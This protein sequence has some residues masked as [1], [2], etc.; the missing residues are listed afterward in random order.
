MDLFHK[1]RSS[2]TDIKI[3][4]EEGRVTTSPEQARFFDVNYSIE[5]NDLGRVNIKLD[6]D[7]LT[8]IYNESMLDDQDALK[9]D[10]FEFLRDM[11]QFAKRNMLRFD[12][13]D[14]TKS[15]LDQRDYQYLAQKT[16]ENAMSE[17]KLFGT[18]KT[19]YQDIGTAKIIVKHS[20][21]VNY[22]NPAGRS[23]RIDSIYVESE[24]G[25]RFRYPHKHLNGAR[26][27][28]MHI[29]NGGNAYDEIGGYISGLSEELSKLKQF[30]SYASRSGVVSETLNDLNQRV[31][32]RMEAIRSEIYSLQKDHSYKE[33]ATQFTPQPSIEVPD[34]IRSNWVDALTIKTFNEELTDVFPYL[35]KLVNEQ[36]KELSYD[37]IVAEEQETCD[38][39]GKKPCECDDKVKEDSMFAE[40]EDQMDDITTFDYDVEEGKDGKALKK[41]E[42]Y[43]VY[44]S[45]VLTDQE[46]YDL[47]HKFHELAYKLDDIGIGGVMKEIKRRADETGSKWWKGVSKE[48]Q[49]KFGK[50]AENFDADVE[51]GRMSEIDIDLQTLANRGDEEDLIAAL[52]GE[53]GPDVADVLQNMMDDLKDELASKGMNDVMNDQDK[54]IEILWDKIVNEYSGDEYNDDDMDSSDADADALKSAG[55][56]SDEDYE[57][58]QPEKG[59]EKNKKDDLPFEPD[60]SPPSAKDQ[61]GNT[62][63]HRARHLAR[64]GMRSVM[65]KEVVEFISSLY[66]RETGTFPKG[67]EGVKIAVKKKFGETAG[68][69]A[70]FVVEKLSAKNQ[71]QGDTVMQDSSELNRIRELSGMKEEEFSYT[72]TADNV[73]AR[74]KEKG[75]RY[76]RENEKEIIGMIP[77]IMKDMGID[78]KV[79]IHRMGYDEDFVSDVLDG[80]EREPDD[81]PKE[82]KHPQARDYA[83]ETMADLAD[84]RKLSGL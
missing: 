29:N 43:L 30:K 10:W 38:E 79:I 57:S 72:R 62:I 8:L 17:S 56:G 47:S 48:F 35:Y 15:N 12:T 4:D 36:P 50:F 66:D 75:I 20:A 23:Q 45:D 78:K 2:F 11:R 71:I 14:I 18:S 53:M 44:M 25:E 52:E 1:I 24:S 77:G 73:A 26:A 32:D 82:P 61:F 16:G 34:D 42:D 40:F 60:D 67:E 84:L 68:R 80:L 33:F 3:G 83:Q 64:K 7:S 31:L 65:P 22:D 9:S 70:G 55:F 76:T 5:G 58:V 69:F 54:M 81:G 28:A 39:C 46:Q 41:A 37:D 27:M 19:S 49:N 6:D 51:E 74:I 63:K 59:S 21:P 13:R